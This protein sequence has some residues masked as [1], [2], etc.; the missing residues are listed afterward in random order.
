MAPISLSELTILVLAS[1][2]TPQA[3]ANARGHLFEVFVARLLQRYGYEEPNFSNLNV[4][5]DGIE[6][7]VVVRHQLTFTRAIAECKAYSRPV[8]ANE[9]TNFYGKLAADRLEGEAGTFGF[10]VALPRL[11]PDG[12]EKARTISARDT[13]F[14]YLGEQDV[15]SALGDLEFIAKE[16]DGLGTVSDHAVV[17][18]EDG[19]FRACV[20][21]DGEA[22]TPL[23]VA[24]WGV[25]ESVPQATLDLIQE[26]PYS[27][28]LVAIDVR[29]GAQR[30]RNMADAS[31]AEASILATVVGSGSDFEYQLP[32]SPQYFIGRKALL[33]LLKKEVEEGEKVVVFNAQ[34]GRGKSSLALKFAQLA[35]DR[36]G[37]AVVF[38]TRT[39]NS[40]R[41]VV[42]V[43]RRVALEAEAKGIISLPSDAS[44][45]SLSSALGTLGSAQWNEPMTVAV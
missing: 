43:L 10:M 20:A 1:G 42:E 18:T 39:A 19:I 8:K 33:D 26:N 14:R 35:V 31:E 3:Q 16:P 6:L 13:S 45:G 4:T 41:Y 9:L 36:G 29:D 24:V 34:S 44:W 30:A 11:S 37:H 7:D 32:A 15:L 23:Y 40:P 17:I 28:G 27:A 2:T 5:A 38:D 12:E 25:D 22:R 21:L